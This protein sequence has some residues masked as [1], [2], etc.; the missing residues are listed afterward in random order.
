MRRTSAA[1]IDCRSSGADLEFQG[2]SCPGGQL[3]QGRGIGW[4]PVLV[5]AGAGELG[6]RELG[7]ELLGQPGSLVVLVRQADQAFLDLGAK[8]GAE[9]FF[10]DGGV[11]ALAGPGGQA[12]S[13]VARVL[14]VRAVAQILDQGDPRRQLGFLLGVEVAGQR[15]DAANDLRPIDVGP[16]R[17]ID[18]QGK[19]VVDPGAQASGV[20]SRAR[21]T[22]APA[23]RSNFWSETL[24]FSFRNSSRSWWP[25]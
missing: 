22:R 13:V 19:L 3:G 23:T 14:V 20:P 5:G 12:F 10:G 16:A 11:I 15:L 1:D 7:L 8:Q 9:L 2:L 6:R 24:A 4:R 17:R 21:G 18:G 25:N